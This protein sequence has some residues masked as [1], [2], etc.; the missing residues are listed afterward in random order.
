MGAAASSPVYPMTDSINGANVSIS[1]ILKSA[2][3]EWIV[4]EVT[5]HSITSDLWIPKA[6]VL[7]ILGAAHQLHSPFSCRRVGDL[8]VRRQ[9]LPG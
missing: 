1:G 3:G 5:D 8:T 6:S 7:L 9:V 4:L 2:S